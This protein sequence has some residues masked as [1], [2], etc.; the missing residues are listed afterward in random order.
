MVLKY[1]RAKPY[2]EI[3]ESKNLRRYTTLAEKIDESSP[4]SPNTLIAG[5]LVVAGNM[6]RKYNL[7]PTK[8]SIV[9]L[10]AIASTIV[11]NTYSMTHP[12]IEGFV[13][14][15]IHEKILVWK[16]EGMEILPLSA[17]QVE[18]I[19]REHKIQVFIVESLFER[20]LSLPYV[21][22][23]ILLE[24]LYYTTLEYGIILAESNIE[25][26]TIALVTAKAKR[27]IQEETWKDLH[28]DFDLMYDYLAD[29]RFVFVNIL[30]AFF[31]TLEYLHDV[32]VFLLKNAK[33]V[34]EQI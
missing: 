28:E 6:V 4:Q 19:Q 21:V 15:C 16:A 30:E 5:L 31:T 20:L 13:T 34:D 10:L 22:P 17:L 27:R 18:Q 25:V 11:V 2:S 1:F 12:A 14:R 32:Q 29:N 24:I 26:E 23:A 3:F 33:L 8:D 7:P 9:Q